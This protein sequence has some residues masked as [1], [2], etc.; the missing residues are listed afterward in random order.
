M[1]VFVDLETFMEAYLPKSF[2]SFWGNGRILNGSP[3]QKLNLT[4]YDWYTGHYQSPG[5]YTDKVA[6]YPILT[7]G[8]YRVQLCGIGDPDKGQQRVLVNGLPE[9]GGTQLGWIDWYRASNTIN[10][11]QEL[12]WTVSKGGRN[13]LTFDI[14]GKNNSSN[15]YNFIGL[16]LHIFP[17]G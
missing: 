8:N 10:L 14:V 15:G 4:G 6:F 12:S 9:N 5:S 7:K 16:W 13:E 3:F 11:V 1:P 2:F 17:Q